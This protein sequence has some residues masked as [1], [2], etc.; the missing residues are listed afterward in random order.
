MRVMIGGRC[1]KGRPSEGRRIFVVYLLQLQ[2][3][4]QG[5]VIIRRGTSS[6]GKGPTPALGEAR[7]LSVTDRKEMRCGAK[8][9]A[10]CRLAR[11][12]LF[13]SEVNIEV[14]RRVR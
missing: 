10:V 7:H 2:Q 14:S 1:G 12:L 11:A 13:S 3:Q 5:L 9:E 4:L 8:R 6:L